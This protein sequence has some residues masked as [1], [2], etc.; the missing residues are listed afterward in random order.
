M[1]RLPRIPCV[2]MLVGCQIMLVGCQHSA[3]PPM[4]ARPPAELNHALLC[5]ATTGRRDSAL[6]SP[7]PAVEM[8]LCAC[9][10]GLSEIPAKDKLADT[11]VQ[12]EP[13]HPIVEMG[14]DLVQLLKI[15]SGR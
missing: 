7:A 4:A 6:Q 14:D 1:S 2:L 3:A 12:M 13:E 5:S 15:F 8:R 9:E 10:A 11:K